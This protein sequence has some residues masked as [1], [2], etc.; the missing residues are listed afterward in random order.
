MKKIYSKNCD[1][2]TFQ[3]KLEWTEEMIEDVK[4]YKSFIHDS[5]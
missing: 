4:N 5:E 1:V 3:W 2:S